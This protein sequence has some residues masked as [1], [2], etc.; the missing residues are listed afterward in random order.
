[1]CS[2]TYERERACGQRATPVRESSHDG[3]MVVVA[4]L[5]RLGGVASR[6]DLVD[7]TSRREVDAALRTGEIVRDAHGRYALPIADA[8]IRAASGLSGTLS[9]RS[10]ALYW[11]WE[12]KTV[13]PE[14]DVTVRHNRVIDEVRRQGVA[15]HRADLRPDEMVG[16]VTSRERTLVDCLRNLPFDEALAVA[17]SALRNRSISKHRLIVLAGDLRGPGSRQAR[18]VA[19]NATHLAANPFESVLRAISLDVDGIDLEAQ[20]VIA[21]ASGRGRPDLVDRDRRLV[22]EAESYSFH[23]RRGDLR[24]DCRR[25]TKLVLLNWRVLRFAWEDVMHHQ[26]YVRECLE[27]MAALLAAEA[28]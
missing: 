13:P 21:D 7:A 20:V 26:D 5:H 3:D 2:L 25:Y 27:S 1:L 19:A 10:A 9:H 15:L 23:S 12:L 11:G 6:R 24:R 22:V 16:R 18:R 14:P 28:A 8:G 17:D 4:V